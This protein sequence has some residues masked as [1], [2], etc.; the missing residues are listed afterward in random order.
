MVSTLAGAGS[1][2]T[3]DGTGTLASFGTPSGLAV[4]FYG[5]YALVA[6]GGKNNLRK[7]VLSTAAV[8]AFAGAGNPSSTNGAASSAT[9]NAPLGICFLQN[10]NAAVITENVGS[11]L[12]QIQ[13]FEPTPLPTGSRKY[14]ILIFLNS[15]DIF[16]CSRPA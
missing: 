4:D 11:Y 16:N 5:N 7:I 12:R 15:N 13:G 6:D 14:Y 3:A 9:F 10:D 8:T 2:G 1:Q